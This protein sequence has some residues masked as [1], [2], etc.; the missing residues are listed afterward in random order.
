MFSTEVDMKKASM[1][2][3]ALIFNTGQSDDEYLS[4]EAEK[5][6]LLWEKR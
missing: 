4:S 1:D 6:P 2:Q 5:N 3:A